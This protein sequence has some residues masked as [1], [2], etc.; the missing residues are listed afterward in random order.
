MDLF[1]LHSAIN[2]VIAVT[3]AMSFGLALLLERWCTS[4]LFRLMYA[5]MSRAAKP[6][7]QTRA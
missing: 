7:R 5:G 2:A 3:L 4:T 1:L 6:A